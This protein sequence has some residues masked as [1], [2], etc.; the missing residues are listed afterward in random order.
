MGQRLISVPGTVNGK[1]IN[2]VKDTGADMTLLREDLVDSRNILEG[3][4]VTLETPIG[5][6]FNAKLAIVNMDTPYYKGVAQV[7]VV[8]GLATEALLGMDILERRSALAVTRAAAKKNREEAEEGPEIMEPEVARDATAALD[9]AD[10]EVPVLGEKEDVTL[11]NISAVNAE[12]LSK[13]QVDDDNLEAIRTKANAIEADDIENGFFWD[14]DILKRKWTSVK[15]R[16]SGTQVVLPS[17]L[18]QTVIKL[19]HDRPL[20]GHLGLEKTKERIIT[21]FYWPGMFREIQEYCASCDICQRTAKQRSGEKVPMI[22]PPIISEPFKKIAMDIVGPLSRTKK[23]NKYI[24]TI[25]DEATRYPEAFPLKNIEAKTVATTL[26]ELISRVGIPEMILTDQGTNFVSTLMKDLYKVF[27]IRGIK[28][29]PYR[30]Q[31]NGRVERFNGTL[32][33]MLKKL[34][35]GENF[36]EWDELIPYALFAYREVPHEETGFS[37]FE[38]LYAWPV[39][40]PTDM[41][42]GLFTGEDVPEVTVVDHVVKIRDRLADVTDVVQR[43]LSDRKPKIKEWYDKNARHR[44]FRPGEEVL[45]L[46]PSDASKMKAQW[47]GPYRIVERVG[48]VNYKVNVGG[49]RRVVTYHVNLL[50]KYK[51]PILTVT[52]ITEHEPSV[53]L[54]EMLE[55]D[56]L[57]NLVIGQHLDREQRQE[58]RKLCHEF[59]DV[60]TSKPGKTSMILHTIRTSSERPICQK[61]YR[62]P[63]A[64]R[65]EVK[66]AIDDM[67]AQDIIEP[68]SSPWS[69]PIVP[70]RKKDG[71][72]R[73]CVDYRKLNQITYFDAYPTPRMDELF[74]KLGQA[75]FLSRLDMT[76]GYWQIPLAEETREKSA[77]VTPFGQFHFRVMP[78]GMKTSAA[79]FLR[80]M[81]KL[82]APLNNV[83]S[84]FD[85]IVVFS[86]TWQE[87]VQHLKALFARLREENLT[88]R[89]SKC[90]FGANSIQ[91]LGHVVGGGKV[92][93]D[94][95]KV[96]AMREYPLP[97]NKKGVRSF[98]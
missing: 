81:D 43:N 38:L 11:E 14:N 93:T 67:L 85:D 45:I 46:L 49:R 79:T 75:N 66:N 80:M 39:R 32:K 35:A 60:L 74:E 64:M 87:H 73:I 3:Q 65:S 90:E 1:E 83:I 47:K 15:K 34:C 56:S 61:P 25:V 51:R 9:S 13:M 78:F 91:C 89:P 23:G 33:S 7:G 48:D 55:D 6:P 70:I 16:K 63:H 62:I 24:L 71:T 28:T 82:L 44:E 41:L 18:R 22:S 94:E 12:V 76:K 27:G 59:A 2:F 36:D 52:A 86:D 54:D 84:Y 88:V 57:E 92:A 19:A 96:R 40:G 30:P 17:K 29:S 58:I 37:P 31:T 26:M 50:R 53:T 68:S 95:K 77:F 42:H 4:N 10:I 20:A 21:C 8:P 5:Q 72:L 98:L 97:V 69:A